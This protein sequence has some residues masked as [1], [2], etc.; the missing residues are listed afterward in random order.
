[1][2]LMIFVYG[3]FGSAQ[4]V[5]SNETFV[6]LQHLR[7]ER[8]MC[9]AVLKQNETRPLSKVL[10]KSERILII[11]VRLPCLSLNTDSLCF[12]PCDLEL[13][14]SLNF[15]SRKKQTNNQ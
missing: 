14:L 4:V 15:C 9:L 5:N 7:E 11:V 8:T 10:V 2:Q 12:I 6:R 1:M 3:I 13:C